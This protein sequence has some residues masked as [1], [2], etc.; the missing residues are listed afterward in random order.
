[1]IKYQQLLYFNKQGLAGI[2]SNAQDLRILGFIYSISTK[3]LYQNIKSTCLAFIQLS[4]DN[5]TLLN[6]CYTY[7]KVS[8]ISTAQTAKLLIEL[9][10]YTTGNRTTE[11]TIRAEF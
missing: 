4:H 11:P 7:S 2:Y 8:M 1:L 10:L 9:F 3:Q 5:Q 6:Y